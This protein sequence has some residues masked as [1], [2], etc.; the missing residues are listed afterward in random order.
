MADEITIR[1]FFRKVWRYLDAQ[2]KGLDA[3]EAAFAVKKYKSHHR[4]GTQAEVRGLIQLQ[5]LSKQRR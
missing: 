5:E 1:R 2:R 4:V 3:R